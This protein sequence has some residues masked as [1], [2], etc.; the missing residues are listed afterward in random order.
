VFPAWPCWPS[1]PGRL[2]PVWRS[3]GKEC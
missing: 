2:A 1:R 3:S